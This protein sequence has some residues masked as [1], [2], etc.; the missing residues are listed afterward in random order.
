MIKCPKCNSEHVSIVTEVKSERNIN[1]GVK[2]IQIIAIALFLITF[3]LSFINIAINDDAF[4]YVFE[5]STKAEST[6]ITTANISTLNTSGQDFPTPITGPQKKDTFFEGIGNIIITWNT[7][8]I[9]FI[10][11]VITSI[12]KV[13]SPHQVYSIEKCI[14]HECEHK[15]KHKSDD[16]NPS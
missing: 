12:I 4:Q 1:D 14:C 2:A 8:K 5:N 9:T 16:Q 15:W 6:S 11:I 13:L 7:A 10:T 3:L